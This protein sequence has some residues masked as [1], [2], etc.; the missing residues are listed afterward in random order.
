MSEYSAS[1]KKSQCLIVP[2]TGLDVD[3]FYA[4]KM[5]LEDF[6]ELLRTKVRICCHSYMFYIA[7]GCVHVFLRESPEGLT[8]WVKNARINDTYSRKSLVAALKM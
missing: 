1:E 7:G 5:S 6:V 8:G 4:Q 3:R 2:L